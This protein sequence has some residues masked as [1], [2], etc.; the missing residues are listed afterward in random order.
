M[1][2]TPHKENDLVAVGVTRYLGWLGFLYAMET[3]SLGFGEMERR[4]GWSRICSI[5]VSGHLGAG[6]EKA[7]NSFC[8]R[9]T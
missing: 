7:L 9:L 5:L 4:G 3:V 8:R 1:K 6:Q 2:F